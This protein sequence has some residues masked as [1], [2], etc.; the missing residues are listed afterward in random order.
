MEF[1]NYITE[2][3]ERWGETDAYSEYEQKASNYTAE[4]E[5]ALAKDLMQVFVEIG[6]LKDLPADAPAV[7]AKIAE[8]QNYI[9]EHYYTC[10]SEILAG[11]GK[12]HVG[13]V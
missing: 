1:E 10:T 5:Q 7:Q 6:K 4:S 9:T 11:L 3:K 13:D 8:L 2:A 12:M